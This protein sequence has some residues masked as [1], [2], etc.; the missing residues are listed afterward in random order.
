M[1]C[2]RTL[3]DTLTSPTQ[4]HLKS[5]CFGDGV[6]VG[7]ALQVGCEVVQLEVHDALLLLLDDLLLL[8]S[9]FIKQLGSIRIDSNA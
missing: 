8:M 6:D 5:L 2:T 3:F 1:H 9:L 4:F 7:V